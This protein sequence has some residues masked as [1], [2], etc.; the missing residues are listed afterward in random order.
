MCFVFLA[1]Y[2]EGH[3]PL[4]N[5]PR[6]ESGLVGADVSR[7][8]HPKPCQP[9]RSLQDMQLQGPRWPC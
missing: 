4:R 8:E 7:P 5:P 3:Q 9:T 1:V 6:K 2:K